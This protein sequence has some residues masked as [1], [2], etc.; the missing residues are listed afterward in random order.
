M[1][2]FLRT[3]I[4][5]GAVFLLPLVVIVTLLGYALGT[6]A[7][8]V[9]PVLDALGLDLWGNIAGIGLVTVVSVLAL[10]GVCFL[11]GL[12]ARTAFGDALTNWTERSVLGRLPQ[13]Q[14]M[15]SMAASFGHLENAQGLSPVLVSIEGGWQIGYLLETLENGWQAVFL[16]QAPTPMSGNV[17][18]FAPERVRAVPFSMLDASRLIQRLGIGSRETLGA[19]DMT[20]PDG[21]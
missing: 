17:M 14:M 1:R 5:G 6:A 11:A 21:Q 10:I 20:Q 16:P 8:L 18:Y 2:K 3:T 12:I 13:Y 19:V 7:D 9:Q 15:K 4:I